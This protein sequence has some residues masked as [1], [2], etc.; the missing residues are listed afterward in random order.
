MA[1]CTI[2]SGDGSVSTVTGYGL[3]DRG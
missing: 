1:K 3:D 2:K